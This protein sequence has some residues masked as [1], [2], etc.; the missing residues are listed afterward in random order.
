MNRKYNQE[1]LR[2]FQLAGQGLW[3]IFVVV[4]ALYLAGFP[5]SGIMV[6][7][8]FL[9]ASGLSLMNYYLAKNNIGNQNDD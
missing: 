9:S 4:L 1:E 7:M 8:G 6:V 5:N 2:L 3:F